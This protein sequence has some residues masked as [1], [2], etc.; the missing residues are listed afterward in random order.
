MSRADWAILLILSV[1]W[2]G[3][4]FFIGIA[5]HSVAPLTLVLLRISL[6]SA[7]LWIWRLIR[8]EQSLYPPH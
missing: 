6:A 7:L 4:F 3:S 1:L 2:G 8:R 5:I